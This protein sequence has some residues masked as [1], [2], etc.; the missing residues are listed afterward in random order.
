MNIPP[1]LVEHFLLT[2]GAGGGV[3]SFSTSLFHWCRCHIVDEKSKF[4][5]FKFI[6]LIEK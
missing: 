3:T 6:I 1:T 2:G 4:N 5:Q